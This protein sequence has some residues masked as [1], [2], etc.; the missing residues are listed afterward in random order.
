MKSTESAKRRRMDKKSKKQARK[1]GRKEG[2][3][4]RRKKRGENG[5]RSCLRAM[6]NNGAAPPPS[7]PL[8]LHEVEKGEARAAAL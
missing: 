4:E 6:K 8:I 7:F 3:K 2:R 5:E 1:E